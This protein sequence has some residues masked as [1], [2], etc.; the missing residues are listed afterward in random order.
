MTRPSGSFLICLAL[1]AIAGTGTLA[2]VLAPVLQLS[3]FGTPFAAPDSFD[4]PPEWPGPG[5]EK[6]TVE[7]SVY[8]PP[9]D[10]DT[11]LADDRLEDKNTT[12][13]P[14]LVDRRPYQGWLLN[15][16]EAVLR[17][18]VPVVKPD[19]NPE[20]LELHPSYQS[21][22]AKAK[23]QVL[24]SVNLL[25]GKAKQFDDGLYAALDQAHYSG[26]G[27]AM[28]S[29]VQLVNRIA[30]KVAGS[31]PAADYLA[32]GLSLAREPVELSAKARSLA[33][34]FLASEVE[35][36]PIGVYTWTPVLSDCFRFLRFLSQ[37]I[38][39][40]GIAKEIARVL[41]EDPALLAD[42]RKTLK[43]YAG[44]TN[45]VVGLTPADLIDKPMPPPNVRVS[46]FPPSSSRETELFM[47]L[48]PRGL[49]PD[50][51]LMRELITAIRSG[52]VDLRPRKDGGWYD[53]QVYALETLLLPERGEET[54]KLLLTKAYKKR[55][56]EAFQAL[57]TK[58][59]ET[60]V[61]QLEK[62]AAAE[63]APM[64][65]AL[66]SVQPRLRVEPCPS[67]FLRTARSY[68]FLANFLESVLG[69]SSLKSLHGLR[70]SGQRA[71]D[72]DSELK[73]MR[74]LFYGWYLL[75]VEDIGLK[76]AFLEDEAVDREKC[77]K[78]AADWLAS[79]QSDP[80]LAADTRIAVPVYYDPSTRATRFWMTLGVRLAK[81]DTRYAVG[82]R[83]RPANSGES[84]EWKAVDPYKLV[85]SEYVIPVDEFAEVEIK[86]GR[87]PNRADLREICDRMKTK[88][89]IVAELKK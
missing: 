35:S 10:P 79:R 69:E 53:Y 47:K 43:F 40:R 52:K 63:A 73:F 5:K 72:L 62:A 2:V 32:A 80:D 20:L 15:A 4:K 19:Q 59:R 86:G 55:M 24:P 29:H 57:V 17:L 76:P 48:F 36:K 16:S 3:L 39:D 89:K 14:G 34:A 18:D 41:A 22:V 85:A 51:N 81:L 33:D 31:S 88:A 6:Y 38:L 65:E 46:L 83:I 82:P 61:R 9:R 21:A 56:L 78:T 87:V 49:P 71:L 12:F 8:T 75:S 50:A 67:Y 37:P 54:N 70:E 11:L 68:A 66:R 28:K 77:E 30:A 44:L 13:D 84:A 60:H 1:I 42:Y 58:R 74:E 45:P 26:D 25:D 27:E 7:F 64:P 23:G